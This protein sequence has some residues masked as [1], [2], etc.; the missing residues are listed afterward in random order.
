MRI[1]QFSGKPAKYVRRPTSPPALV[2]FLLGR[3]F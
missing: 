1:A 3:G 2:V